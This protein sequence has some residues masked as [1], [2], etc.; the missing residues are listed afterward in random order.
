MRKGEADKR[1]VGWGKAAAGA[2]QKAKEGTAPFPSFRLFGR[3]VGVNRL[4]S[5]LITDTT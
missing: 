4:N 1:A 2:K 3:P 5:L